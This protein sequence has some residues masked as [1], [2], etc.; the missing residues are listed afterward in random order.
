MANNINK[1]VFN[2]ILLLLFCLVYSSSSFSQNQSYTEE[3]D[4][5]E[6]RLNYN[7]DD[8]VAGNRLREICREQNIISTCIDSLNNLVDKH[9]KNKNARYQ[10][11]LAYVDEVPGHSLFKQGWYSTRSMDH[12]SALLENDPVDWSAFYIRGL[13]GIF[14]P[15]SFRRLPGAIKDL[16]K[17]IEISSALPEGLQKSYHVYAYI[18]LGDAYVKN[19]EIEEAIKIYR[20][21]NEIENSKKLEKRLSLNTEEL[22]EFVNNIRD[23]D[24]PV[25]TDISFLLDGGSSRL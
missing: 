7:P 19:G 14:W 18:A 25:D 2:K 5:I 23:R 9:P 24:K 6:R 13:N 20:R 16:K 21:G 22:A 15:L 11:A 12:M 10:A 4:S 17:C 8:I 3:F 1:T